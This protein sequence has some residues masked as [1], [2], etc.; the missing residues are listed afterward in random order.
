SA[1]GVEQGERGEV[2]RENLDVLVHALSTSYRGKRWS[3]GWMHSAEVLPKPLA[4]S[5]PILVTGSSMQSM[6]FNATHGHGW[7]TYPRAP[8]VQ[9]NLVAEWRG[10]VRDQCGDEYKPFTQS[11]GLDL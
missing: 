11:L 5:V 9:R 2:F 6:K 8:S 3:G 10:V 7:M 4:S 1:F